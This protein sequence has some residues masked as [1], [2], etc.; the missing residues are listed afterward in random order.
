VPPGG[1]R[2]KITLVDTEAKALRASILLLGVR[3]LGLDTESR[4][5][6]RRGENYPIALVQIATHKRAFLYRVRPDAPYRSLKRL[7]ENPRIRKIVQGAREEARELRRDLGIEARGFVDLPT[8]AKAAGHTELNLRAL[9]ARVLGIRITK[10]AQRSNWANPELST[11][12]IEY[13]ATDAWA[14]LAVYEK[15]GVPAHAA[16]EVRGDEPA[17]RPQG[18]GRGRRR[19]RRGRGR[20]GSRPR[21]PE[22]ARP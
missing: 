19:G 13:A 5:S 2:G 21:K 8:A 14:C 4:P 3:T 6:F 12:Q 17:T 22:T 20:G 15:L 1:F 11:A 10:S 18:R 16:P 7:I 9:A